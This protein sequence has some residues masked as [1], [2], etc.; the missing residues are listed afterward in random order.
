MSVEQVS[1]QQAYHE[2]R[3]A[4]AAEVAKVIPTARPFPERK[5]GFYG[6]RLRPEPGT[7]DDDE[8]P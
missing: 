1:A 2:S 5:T 4:W 7:L 8:Q 6:W 3:R